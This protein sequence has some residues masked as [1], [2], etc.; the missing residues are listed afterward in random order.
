PS[1]RNRFDRTRGRLANKKWSPRYSPKDRQRQV[2]REKPA[3]MKMNVS[4]PPKTA[5]QEPEADDKEPKPGMNDSKDEVA[6]KN[7]D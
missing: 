2:Q 1:Q 6:M 5:S 7:G 4:K 3:G